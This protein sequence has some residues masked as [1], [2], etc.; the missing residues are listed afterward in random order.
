MS[1]VVAHGIHGK[2]RVD[3]PAKATLEL[4][5]GRKTVGRAAVT[6]TAAATKRFKVKL[7]PAAARAVS[8]LTKVTLVL[9]F[10][11]KDTAGNVT[12][13]SRTLKLKA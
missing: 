7:K 8:R 4:R 9:R 1:K 13:T 12:K 3:E 5:R 11:V 2:L 10:T 6:F